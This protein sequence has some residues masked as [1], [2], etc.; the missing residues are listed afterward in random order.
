MKKVPDVYRVRNLIL[1][2]VFYSGNR[3]NSKIPNPGLDN[4][5]DFFTT[6]SSTVLVTV[7]ISNDCL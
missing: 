4:Y 6:T 7:E 1:E 5:F 2:F 3:V